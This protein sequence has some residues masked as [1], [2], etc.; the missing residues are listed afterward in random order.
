MNIPQ[1]YMH[2]SQKRYAI[3]NEEVERNLYEKFE[4]YRSMFEFDFYQI[5]TEVEQF[6]N[7]EYTILVETRLEERVINQNYNNK[8]INLSLA[9][10]LLFSKIKE[11]QRIVK[12]QKGSIY[13]YIDMLPEFLENYNLLSKEINENCVSRYDYFFIQALLSHLKEM[14]VLA[15]KR[16][17]TNYVANDQ[18]EYIAEVSIVLAEK[19]SN[20]SVS[21]ED[22]KLTKHK[23]YD[24]IEK[25]TEG[26]NYFIYTLGELSKL[27]STNEYVGGILAKL[28]NQY[29]KLDAPEEEFRNLLEYI[30]YLNYMGNDHGLYQMSMDELKEEIVNELYD[31]TLPDVIFLLEDEIHDFVDDS[32]LEFQGWTHL[33]KC[34]FSSDEF[35]NLVSSI[36]SDFLNIVPEYFPE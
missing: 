14:L 2:Y 5:E 18:L 31:L 34:I 27:K 13:E 29:I 22:I 4:I 1:G 35:Y 21:Y 33:K 15:Y 36:K 24:Q 32:D 8:N 28:K 26:A 23:Q 12:A 25:L 6:E 16:N 20:F 11:M 3:L 19:Y 9:E 7:G 30:G 10:I 17:K